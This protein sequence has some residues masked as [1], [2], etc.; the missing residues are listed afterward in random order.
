MKG[1]LM[2]Q[3]FGGG[4]SK[5]LGSFHC[6]TYIDRSPLG[7]F[8]KHHTVELPRLGVRGLG[9]SVLLGTKRAT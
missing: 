9:R 1:D 4:L 2:S 7:S 6:G 5:V 8:I 3:A